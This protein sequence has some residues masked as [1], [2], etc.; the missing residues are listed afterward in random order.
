MGYVNF[1]RKEYLQYEK[2]FENTG[3]ECVEQEL[4]EF[5]NDIESMAFELAYTR[6]RLAKL[7][8]EIEKI[9]ERAE[10]TLKKSRSKAS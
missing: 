7:E 4:S 10:E 9:I 5:S 8:S 2:E 3:M 1:D 6:Y